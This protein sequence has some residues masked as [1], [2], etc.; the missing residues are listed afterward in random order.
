MNRFNQAK[1]ALKIYKAQ[2]QLEK[3]ILEIEGG[4]GA[5]VIEIT[6]NQKIKKVHIDA[7]RVDLEN[8]EE[9]EKWV[10]ETMRKAI[11]QSQKLMAETLKPFMGQLG[12]LSM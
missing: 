1:S 7:D 12:D 3:E 11:E 6:G 4:G 10:E 5:I 9:L 2:K 8:I